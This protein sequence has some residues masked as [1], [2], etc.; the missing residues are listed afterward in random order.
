[1]RA[2][3]GRCRYERDGE[4]CPENVWWL[5]HERTWKTTPVDQDPASDGNLDLDLDNGIY[6]VL[7]GEDLAEA[8][9][10]DRPLHLNHHATCKFKPERQ[11]PAS[12]SEPLP[13]PSDA[14]ER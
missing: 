10:Q 4:R 14:P 2:R 3:L 8:R 6:Y 11:T 1:M 7:S 13:K 9:A 12:G 5:R